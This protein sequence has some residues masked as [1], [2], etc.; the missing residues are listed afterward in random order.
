MTYDNT[1]SDADGV[2]DAPVNNGSVTTNELNSY[3]ILD[4][5]A[6]DWGAAVEAA[7]TEVPAGGTILVPPVE[8]DQTT[9][10][11][12]DKSVTICS[13]TLPG[14]ANAGDDP[15]ILPQSDISVLKGAEGTQF[16]VAGLNASYGLVGSPT[17]PMIKA[18][19]T[20]QA[21]DVGATVGPTAT[22]ELAQESTNDNLNHSYLE[23]IH[24]SQLSGDVVKIENTSGGV[25]NVNACRVHVRK[26]FQN[27]GY[28][29]NQVNGVGNQLMAQEVEGS[30]HTGGIRM[31]G[32]NS[33]A[34]IGYA[35]GNINQGIV[36]DGKTS[37]G[38]IVHT[39]LSYANAFVDN[40]GT[41]R[42][43]YP[44]SGIT[45]NHARATVPS[46][47]QEGDV[48]LDDGTNTSDGN[49]H[50]RYYDGAGWNDL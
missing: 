7:L 44:K 46:G 5:D 50:Y 34:Y 14:S 9:E 6:S 29:I 40:D 3:V 10:P 37:Y 26:S 2:I 35:E 49:P 13:L 38:F 16:R 1:D 45:N 25:R 24:G 33:E 43:D 48:Y 21:R 31:A 42:W 20:L 15:R 41:N 27:D 36:F 22:I 39:G 32:D 4:P 47:V 28:A 8:Y 19:S 17:V 12:V 18:R 30:N 11:L 23:N